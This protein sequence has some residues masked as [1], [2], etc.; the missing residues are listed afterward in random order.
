HM[1]GEQGVLNGMLRA[2]PDAILVRNT[3]ALQYFIQSGV[4]LPL[5]GDFSLNIAN[6]KAAEL[7][8]AHGLKKVTPSYDLNIQQMV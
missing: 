3:G 7:F 8:L 6:H 1:P 4:Q 2:Q 5:F